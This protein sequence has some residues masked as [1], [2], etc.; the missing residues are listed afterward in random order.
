[1]TPQAFDSDNA[2]ERPQDPEAKPWPSTARRCVG[3]PAGRPRSPPAGGPFPRLAAV[4]G[5]IRA[6]GKTNEHKAAM[7]LPGVPPLAGKVVVG[8]ALF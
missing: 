7:E 8:D 4:A 2:V 3:A 6:D 1:M 5:L